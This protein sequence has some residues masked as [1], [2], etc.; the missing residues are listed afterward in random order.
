MGK[1]EEQYFNHLYTDSYPLLKRYVFRKATGSDSEDILQETY[2]QA[3]RNIRLLM[4][5][6][7]SMGWLMVTCKNIINRHLAQ[8]KKILEH[9]VAGES[10]DIINNISTMDNYDSVY[11]EELNKMISD[12]AYFML[13]KKYVEGYS[14]EELAK[15]LNITDGACKMRLKRAKKEARKKLSVIFLVLLFS[16]IRI[17]G[18]K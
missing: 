1:K 15:Q 14:I 12:D 13:V 5:H 18:M 9:T 6:P 3:Y 7:N 8:N 11:M 16:L 4:E 17:G 10:E 2:Y